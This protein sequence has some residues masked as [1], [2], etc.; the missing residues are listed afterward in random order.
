MKFIDMLHMSITNLWKRKVRTILTVLGV[1]IGVAA[2]VVMV[3]LG[4]GL[5]KSVM[6]EMKSYASLTAIQV[7]APYDNDSKKESDKK[8]LSDNLV[9]ELSELPNVK[10]AA[11]ILETNI[12]AKK[13]N[14]S[15]YLQL[16]GV[17]PEYLLDQNIEIKEGHLPEQN[18][19]KLQ[20]FFGNQVLMNFYDKKGQGYWD[21]GELPDVDL[22]NDRIM[23]VVDTDSYY[24][25]QGSTITFG[26]DG[27]NNAPPKQPKK[28]F[29]ETAGVMAG[30][31]NTWSS[32][33]YYTFCD[34]DELKKVLKKEFKDGV[35]PG[36][37]TRK[38][39]KAYK[40]I[41]YS[42]IVVQAEDMKY[43][44]GLTQMIKE[45]GYEAYND[46]EWIQQQ[47]NEMNMI[48]GVLGG[49]GAVSLLV[50]AIGIANTMMMSI[51]ERTKEI[52]VMKVLGCDMRN[53]QMM[54]LFEAGF[55][56]LIG[57]FIGLIISFSLSFVINKIASAT[58]AL[59]IEGNLSYIPPWLALFA[60][61]FALFVGMLSGFF[62]SRRAMKLSPLAAIRND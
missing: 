27:E 46:A 45:M 53:I 13:G 57:G 25:S 24:G 56:G 9:K 34:I 5:N 28:Y 6:E 60:L 36:Q 1:V 40:E 15:G 11:P 52:G 49:I 3:S 31:E 42:T 23:Y 17:T 32:N 30:D 62:P 38:G 10:Y 43:V 39:G 26:Q 2:I 12:I 8:Y 19:S 16:Q 20:L 48:E 61:V 59:G 33:S 47:Q 58:G 29:F 7:R 14:Y 18:S 54:F 21:T 51:Y 55:I 41:F 4:L 22:M 37:P 44:E 35:I 50:A